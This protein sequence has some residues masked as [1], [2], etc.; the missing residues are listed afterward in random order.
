MYPMFSDGG[1]VGYQYRKF[2]R[3]ENYP[4]YITVRNPEISADSITYDHLVGTESSHI[5]VLVE[6]L[7]SAIRVS[8]YGYDCLPLWGTN[9]SNKQLARILHPWTEYAII[10]D[11][12]N[13]TVR[14]RQRDIKARLNA[15][16]KVAYIVKTD[17]DPKYCS[18]EQL[19]ELL[20]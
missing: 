6:D 19:G 7:L 20:G 2:P 3:D 10:L 11:N 12:D 18:Q 15:H 4:K 5:L 1:L 17:K 9:L 14:R 13:P 8:N 16:G